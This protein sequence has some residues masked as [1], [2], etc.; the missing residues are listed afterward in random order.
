M[1]LEDFFEGFIFVEHDSAPDGLGGEEYE[2]KEGARFRAGIAEISSTEAAIAYRNGL[3]AVFRIT[4]DLSITLR[5][6]DVVKRVK[7]GRLY[8]ITSNAADTTTP[9]V[10]A[11]KHR[12]CM[13]EVIS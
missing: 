11:V 9:D 5:Q 3:Q 10:A 8:R 2:L 6:N 12:W 7:D 4:T 13:A 1:A